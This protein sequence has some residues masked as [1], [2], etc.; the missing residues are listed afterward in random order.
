MSH[1]SE[2]AFLSQLATLSVARLPDLIVT[3]DL[4]SR[5]VVASCLEKIAEVNPTLDAVVQLRG[6]PALAEAEACDRR[7]PGRANR[8]RQDVGQRTVAT[9]R[10]TRCPRATRTPRARAISELMPAAAR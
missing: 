4:S 7:Q 3:C 5:E 2:S 9:T 1:A 6:D 10:H 8:S